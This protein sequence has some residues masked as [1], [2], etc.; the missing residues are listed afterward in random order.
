VKGEGCAS[1]PLAPR[2]PPTKGSV[3]SISNRCD[4]SLCLGWVHDVVGD[5]EVPEHPVC[6]LRLYPIAT[7]GALEEVVS[8][9]QVR[10]HGGEVEF[11]S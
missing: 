3:S 4:S 6:L 1:C 8:G 5:P 9:Y 7:A 11:L 10:H 2:R